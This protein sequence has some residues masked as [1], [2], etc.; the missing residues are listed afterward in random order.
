MYITGDSR[1]KEVVENISYTIQYGTLKRGGDTKVFITIH[2]VQHLST[3]KTC[4][5]TL[6]EVTNNNGNVEIM[7]GY[8]NKKIGVINQRVIE[9]V[10][11]NGV[12]KNIVFNLTGT[13]E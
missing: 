12:E 9:K 1:V 13:I 6:P 10:L 8:D 11:D 5:C 3:T 2:D 7:I 4:G